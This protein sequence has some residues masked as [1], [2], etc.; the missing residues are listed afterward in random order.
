MILEKVDFCDT[1][2]HGFLFQIDAYG[3]LP[4]KVGT[5]YIVVRDTAG[6]VLI[7]LTITEMNSY[8]FSLLSEISTTVETYS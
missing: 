4:P 7:T 1:P 6:S 5:T 8:D 2:P 3:F